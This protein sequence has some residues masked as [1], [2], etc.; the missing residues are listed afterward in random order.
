MQ[1]YENYIEWQTK[2]SKIAKKRIIFIYIIGFH[3]KKC[4]SL[5][6]KNYYEY[7]IMFRFKNIS[8]I[9]SSVM[10]LAALIACGSKNNT[11]VKPQEDLTAKKNLQG[12]WLDADDDD[13]FFRVKGDS[14]YFPDSTSAPAYFRIER[15]SFIIVGGNTV[16]YHIIKQTPHL[17]VFTNQ[18]GERVKLSKTSDT[19]YLEMFAPKTIQHVNQN[20]VLKRDT[21]YFHNEDKYHCYVQVN[22]TTY[23]VAVASCNEDGVEVDNVYFD[24]II[25]LNVYKGAARLFSRDLRKEFFK[26]EVPEQ[27]LKQAV[28]SD[29]TF[30]NADNEGIHFFA[31][32][33]IPETS[34]SYMVETIVT[35]D[36]KINKRIKK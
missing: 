5:H 34:I 17:F 25:N 16:K 11:Q 15:D 36:G 33:A 1:I 23:K 12:I 31:V 13:V 29:M 20:K 35:Y 26:S 8:V 9:F 2:N 19:S 28:L 22:P 21:V 4:V 18:N 6:H 32:L 14:V 27:F 10:L 7:I 24:N 30:L 3:G